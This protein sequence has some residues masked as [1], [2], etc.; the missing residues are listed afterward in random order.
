MIRCSITYLDSCR[1]TT[2]RLHK[3]K[4]GCSYGPFEHPCLPFLPNGASCRSIPARLL[5]GSPQAKIRD[6][7]DFIACVFGL[8]SG[9]FLGRSGAYFMR[10]LLLTNDQR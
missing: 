8:C 2:P 6:M 3:V 10:A 1:D 4:E 5:P 7:P 9:I